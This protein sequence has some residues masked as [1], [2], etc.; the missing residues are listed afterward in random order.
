L[1]N[2]CLGRDLEIAL[3]YG[4][5]AWTDVTGFGILGQ[6]LEL[7]KG[8]GLRAELSCS[9]LPFYPSALEMQER[10]ETTGRNKPRRKKKSM[11]PSRN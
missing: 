5:H 6:S 8:S 11:R 10:G 3:R 7:A 2:S 4:I 1:E 9:A